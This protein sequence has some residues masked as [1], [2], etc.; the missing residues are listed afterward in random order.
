MTSGVGDCVPYVI[1]TDQLAL[2]KEWTGTPPDLPLP[3]ES[4]QT[5]EHKFGVRWETFWGSEKGPTLPYHGISAQDRKFM[6][7]PIDVYEGDCACRSDVLIVQEVADGQF[8]TVKMTL[9]KRADPANILN[10]TFSV[11]YTS[12]NAILDEQRVEAIFLLFE[13]RKAGGGYN[14]CHFYSQ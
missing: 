6:A 1:L 13:G 11:F 7:I 4:A 8:S 5:D 10:Y 14:K 3:S 12:D 9:K 2:C